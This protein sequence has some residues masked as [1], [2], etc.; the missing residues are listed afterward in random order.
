VR[1]D[2]PERDQDVG[3]FGGL[4]GDVLAGQRRMTGGGAGVDGEDDRGH[5][6][7]PV[8]LGQVGDRGVRFSE[9]LK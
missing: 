3:V 1:I 8:T 6:R 5:L 4:G 9:D 2:R 7:R